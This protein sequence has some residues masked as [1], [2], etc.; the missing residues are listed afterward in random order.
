VRLLI[1]LLGL[2]LC[3]PD[4]LSA[5]AQKLPST[6]ASGNRY[7]PLKKWALERGFQVHWR[8]GAQT[9]VLTNRWA[10]LTFTLES[11]K[12]NVNG[13]T[14]WLSLNITASKD[15]LFVGQKDIATLLNPILF[16]PK[17]APKAKVR[18]VAVCAGHGGKDPGFFFNTHQEKKY[19][20]LL[21]KEIEKAIAG[22]GLKTVMIRDS[23]EY[24][25]P[26]DQAAHANKARA[27][28]FVTVHYNA[29]QEIEAKGLEVYCLTPE[30][31]SSTN[32][33]AQR[34]RSPGNKNDKLNILLAYQMQK[35]ILRDMDMVDRGVKRAAFLMLRPLQMPGVL[36]EGGFMT[37]PTDA[38]KIF[39]P[40]NRRKMARA[41][42]DGVL[43]YKR[44]VE[45]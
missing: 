1:V 41:V 11:R 32:G 2:V 36:I 6:P 37:N 16:P 8:R 15:T 5:P 40:A 21:A 19:T 35:S 43:E 18:T 34:E 38:H 10:R 4:S 20:L 12:A 9:A 42:V 13:T 26:E 17:L 45:R 7:V 3:A 29:A 25:S 44:L 14:V 30:G 22:T 27:D 39:D 24:V 23:D 28:L 33:G 31:A